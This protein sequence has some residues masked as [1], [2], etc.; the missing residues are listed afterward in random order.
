ME[1]KRQK[2]WIELCQVLDNLQGLE[3][4]TAQGQV[5]WKDLKG[6]TLQEAQNTRIQRNAT[7][8]KEIKDPELTKLEL[9]LELIIYK[10]VTYR[11]KSSDVILT[12]TKNS[13]SGCQPVNYQQFH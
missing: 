13:R 2:E 4:C 5:I 1:G 3:K 7:G 8:N 9:S 6:W 11:R 12:L 10:E